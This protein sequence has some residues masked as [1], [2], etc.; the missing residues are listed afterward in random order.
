MAYG[1]IFEDHAEYMHVVPAIY[2]RDFCDK[3]STSYLHMHENIEI[4]RVTDGAGSFLCG[5]GYIPVKEKDIVVIN[6]N[7]LH[8]SVSET[9]IT[10]DCFIPDRKFLFENG[11]DTNALLFSS[12]IKGDAFLNSAFDEI[13]RVFDKKGE[14]F[15]LRVS[16][17][18]LSVVS[19][20]CT[21]YSAPKTEETKND[22]MTNAV[23]YILKNI[24]SHI[25]LDEAAAVSGY[26]KYHFLRK[27]KSFTGKTPV[28]FIN[29]QRCEYA[30]N[31][32]TNTNYSV[33]EVADAVGFESH[34]YF[35][36]VFSSFYGVSPAEYARKMRKSAISL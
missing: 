30:K 6:S 19:H 5:N 29:S 7:I 4:L 16:A 28:D 9:G 11:A 33:K 3:N 23:S 1:I 21:N 22:G 8:G 25:S 18:T 36:K 13:H 34:S 2:H 14:F 17:I 26:S 20:L 32:L 35:S 31:L 10:Y 12:P 27:F 24:S 15:S